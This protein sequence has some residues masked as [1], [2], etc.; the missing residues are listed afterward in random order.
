MYLLETDIGIVIW[1]DAAGLVEK[2]T[3]DAYQ[4]GNEDKE[5]ANS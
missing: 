1:V 2:M 4:D 5:D 3:N